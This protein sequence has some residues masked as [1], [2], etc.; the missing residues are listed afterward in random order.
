MREIATRKLS[1]KKESLRRLQGDP[2]VRPGAGAA[3]TLTHGCA[4]APRRPLGAS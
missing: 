4:S 3:P 1:L 2:R